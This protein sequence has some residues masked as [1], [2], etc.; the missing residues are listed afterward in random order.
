PT[1]KAILVPLDGS[2]AGEAALPY[3]EALARAMNKEIILLQVLEAVVFAGDLSGEVAA[4][5]EHLVQA[6]WKAAED[7]LSNLAKRLR[8]K[9]VA[10]RYQILLGAPANEIAR[11]ASEQGVD[12]IAIST[13]GRS[14]IARWA[15]GSVTER[16][17]ATVD[18]P[19]L[20][21]RAQTTP[22]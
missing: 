6:Q 1:D 19:V 11:T 10:S 3:A 8:R 16:I 7:Y 20:I 21:V 5:S 9:K 2:E 15:L 14:G 12:L 18:I 22:A 13:H 17:V 4:Y